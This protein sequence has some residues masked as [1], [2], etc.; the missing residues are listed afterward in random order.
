[1]GLVYQRPPVSLL[2]FT[3]YV[4][5]NIV[6]SGGSEL[7]RG[8]K[9]VDTH[10]LFEIRKNRR[11]SNIK[12]VALRKLDQLE[13]SINLIDLRVPPGNRLEE[14]QGDTRGQHRSG[15]TISFEFASHGRAMERMK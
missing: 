13:A 1:L 2:R 4:A 9:D 6:I 15:S 8:F 7:V 5:R 3:Y 12:A 10:E 11:W 14:L